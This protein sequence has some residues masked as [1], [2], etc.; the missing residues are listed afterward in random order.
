MSVVRIMALDAFGRGG[1]TGSGVLLTKTE[2]VEVRNVVDASTR[3]QKKSTVA[4]EY[5]FIITNAHVIPPNS[6]ASVSM[7]NYHE[8]PI[9]AIIIG[10]SAFKDIAVLAIRRKKNGILLQSARGKHLQQL[11]EGELLQH[12]SRL[13]MN[14]PSDEV[15][16][17]VAR[18]YPLL[19]ER[20]STTIGAV[21]VQTV[22]VSSTR[23]EVMLQFSG[24][25]NPGNSGGGLFFLGDD[26]ARALDGQYI[27]MPTFK[28]QDGDDV[29]FCIP[30]MC[31]LST[32]EFIIKSY[33]SNPVALNQHIV[34]AGFDTEKRPMASFELGDIIVVR[35]SDF[36]E[37]T[38]GIMNPTSNDPDVSLPEGALS[39]LVATTY[40]NATIK[41]RLAETDLVATLSEM[42]LLFPFSVYD[43]LSNKGD[44][45]GEVS[46]Q[47]IYFEVPTSVRSSTPF[48]PMI[49][50]ELGY[51]NAHKVTH[52]KDAQE[53]AEVDRAVVVMDAMPGSGFEE[54]IGC[55][56]RTHDGLVVGST[57]GIEYEHGVFSTSVGPL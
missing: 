19:A 36:E 31:V 10:V 21:S 30:S 6:L 48:G 53:A 57:E 15:N 44:K 14:L 17:A 25:L 42:L 40:D 9:P 37:N 35:E 16:Q 52:I 49:V 45:V 13:A 46:S 43:V 32:V 38:I 2:A 39:F 51:H 5:L 33:A 4:Y 7:E 11:F 22:P 23:H 24:G 3:E 28:P 12:A 34:S 50:G 29:G 56:L 26:N 55:I 18:G 47:P 41:F 20:L 54:H 27:G 1:G 8:V